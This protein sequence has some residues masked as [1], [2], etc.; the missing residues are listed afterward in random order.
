MR[1]WSSPAVPRIQLPGA[2]S[3]RPVTAYNT[4]TG[5][6]EVVGPSTGIASMYVCGI[7]PY[8]ATHLGHAFTYLTFDLLNRVWRDYGLDVNYAQ[9]VTDVDDP[10][11]E[12]ANATGQDWVE[13]AR[14][15]TDLFRTDME[16]LRVIPPAHYV[17]ATESI[18]D[19]IALVQRLEAVGLVYLL[20]DEF[21]DLYFESVKAPGFGEVAHLDRAA[22]LSEFAEHGGDPAR[23]GK[24]DALD[25]LLWRQQRPVEPSWGSPFGPGRP[26]WHIECAAIALGYLGDTIDV[27]GGGRDLCFPHH[28]MSSAHAR[29]ATGR[30]FSRAYLHVGMVGMDGEKMSKS[31]GNLELVSRLRDNGV[32]P[33]VIRL[34][35]L[36]HHYRSDWEWTSDQVGAAQR[37]LDAWQTAAHA[38]A[39]TDAAPTVRLL[40]EALRNDLDAPTALRTIDEWSSAVLAGDGD[41]P[42]APAAVRQAVDALLGIDL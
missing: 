13:L 5:A 16:A 20:N 31:L 6:L 30:P 2:Q 25:A 12:R 22:Q 10:L 35:L 28:E 40:R 14:D 33:R 7:T 27:Q 24:R 38:P 4:S 23:P 17:G 21:P 11:L 39:G 37:R 42:L 9:N 34:A 1:S 32:D 26:G 29:A 36:D 19:V 18:D 41:D 3:D 8:D 15:Q